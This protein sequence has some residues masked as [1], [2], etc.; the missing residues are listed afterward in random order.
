MR[1]PGHRGDNTAGPR[2][3]RG[4]RASE[5][6]MSQDHKTKQDTE[7]L[8]PQKLLRFIEMPGGWKPGPSSPG[9]GVNA[10]FMSFFKNGEKTCHVERF[11]VMFLLPFSRLRVGLFVFPV[12]PSFWESMA[13]LHRTPS[14]WLSVTGLS[15]AASAPPAQSSSAARSPISQQTSS[16]AEHHLSVRALTEPLAARRS[17]S[18]NL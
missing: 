4:T 13:R 2:P 7:L 16:G 10:F 12:K 9:C 6:R 3:S 17:P 14:Q 18:G 15:L 5:R 8:Y 1:K 11:T